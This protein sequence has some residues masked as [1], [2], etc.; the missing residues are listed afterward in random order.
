MTSKFPIFAPIKGYKYDKLAL[1][2]EIKCECR[3]LFHKSGAIKDRLN[4]YV[5]SFSV[6][7]D[8]ELEDNSYQYFDENKKRQWVQGKYN[9]WETAN[10][11]YIP[12]DE[13][14]TWQNITTKDGDIEIL[15]EKYREPWVWRPEL[16]GKLIYL[17]SYL[18][19]FPF[20]YLQCV[21]CIIMQPP[22]IGM[23]HQDSNRNNTYYED[24]FAAF[25]INVLHGGGILRAQS[26]NTKEIHDI[27]NKYKLFHFD[28]R[29][30]H[31]VTKTSS[32]RLQLR[33]YGKILPGYNYLD[34]LDLSEAIW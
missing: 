14:S 30:L 17:R 34:M 5:P 19:T 29:A 32:F 10:L 28:D 6:C 15:R 20:E 2:I 25:T 31:G 33:I 9:A 1:S 24:G 23:I 16:D 13:D 12:G 18:E 7:T 11:T 27:D 8:E 3:N 26:Y 4:Y 22:G 21:R